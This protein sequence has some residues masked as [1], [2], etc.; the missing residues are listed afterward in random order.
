[1]HCCHGNQLIG[2]ECLAKNMI[3]EANL[4]KLGSG[5]FCAPPPPPPSLFRLAKK[6]SPN[7]VNPIQALGFLSPCN[8]GGFHPFHKL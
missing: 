3:K 4:A 7:R 2:G 8:T 5:P 6:L 1:M